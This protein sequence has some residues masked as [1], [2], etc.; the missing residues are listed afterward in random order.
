VL[1][2]IAAALA[3]AVFLWSW[4]TGRLGSLGA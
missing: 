2:E 3:M 4:V 1:G